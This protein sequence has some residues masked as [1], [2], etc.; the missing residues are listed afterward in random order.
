MSKES[1][2]LCG[3]AQHAAILAALRFYQSGGMGDPSNRSDEIHDIAT[4]GDQVISSLDEEGIDELAE[5]INLDVDVVQALK[6]LKESGLSFG[7]CVTVFGETADNSPLIGAAQEIHQEEGSLEIDDTTVISRGDEPGA[8]VMA[9]VWVN[10]ADAGIYTPSVHFD[11]LFGAIYDGLNKLSE[12]SEE[13]YNHQLYAV[14]LEAVTSNHIN[15]LDEFDVNEGSVGSQDSKPVL[16]TTDDGREINVSAEISVPAVL[17]LVR[18]LES[19]DSD[20][21]LAIE[22]IEA[23]KPKI[24]A[25]LSALNAKK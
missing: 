24:V 3:D 21:S 10:D 18:K 2:I 22:F 13:L 7:D 1:I 8:Y 25:L 17:E 19:Y 5:Q 14:F 4:N 20:V 16:R 23:H 9:W 15:E 6:L 12:G 11:N